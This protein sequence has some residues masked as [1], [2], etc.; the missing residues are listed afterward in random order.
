MDDR[1]KSSINYDM[2]IGRD[3]LTELGMVLNFQ[4]KTVYWD[5]DTLRMR[6]K[7]NLKTLKFLTEVYL[8]ANVPKL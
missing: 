2:I 5:K 1:S 7:E 4:E 6:E 8:T 3:L